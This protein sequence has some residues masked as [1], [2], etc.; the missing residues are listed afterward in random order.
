MRHT[1]ICPR[2]VWSRT[3]RAVELPVSAALPVGPDPAVP[4]QRTL[5][6][7]P[8]AV[9]EPREPAVR[10][11]GTVQSAPSRA[12]RVGAASDHR[13]FMETAVHGPHRG[14][15]SSDLPVGE[16]GRWVGERG[17][18]TLVGGCFQVE[19]A[20]GTPVRAEA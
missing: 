14:G 18:E 8:G 11:S 13:R 1:T 16:S 17:P 4:T 7:L 12:V 9:L 3:E 19:P 5:P 6:H 10:E 15:R 2:Y 20:V